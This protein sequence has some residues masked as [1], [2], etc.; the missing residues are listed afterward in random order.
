MKVRGCLCI[1]PEPGQRPRPIVPH[2]SGPGPGSA[3]CE[4]TIRLIGW[5]TESW[6][7]RE[8]ASLD[9]SF[10]FPN[11]GKNGVKSKA[12]RIEL[13]QI[14]WLMLIV[15]VTG[16]PLGLETWKNGKLFSSQGKMREF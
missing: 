3:R 13:Q 11:Y 4:Y 15:V 10:F 9:S 16:F 2:C 6:N 5:E 14:L 1:T 12:R 8:T 7:D